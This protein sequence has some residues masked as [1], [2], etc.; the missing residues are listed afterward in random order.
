M[1]ALGCASHP[2]PIERC[3][4]QIRRL[5]HNT[6]ECSTDDMKELCEKVKDKVQ[7]KIELVKAKSGVIRTPL[8]WCKQAVN[9]KNISLGKTVWS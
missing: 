6:N 4:S 7:R 9:C 1:E 5:Y 2:C 3:P 8:G